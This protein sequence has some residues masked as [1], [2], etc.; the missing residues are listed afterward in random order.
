MTSLT[1]ALER[2]SSGYFKEGDLVIDHVIS[3]EIL[4]Q[5]ITWATGKDANSVFI[6]GTIEEEDA[7]V[8]TSADQLQVALNAWWVWACADGRSRNSANMADSLSNG[9]ATLDTLKTYMS[10]STNLRK[11]NN[12]VTAIHSLDQAQEEFDKKSMSH[13]KIGGSDA[14][15]DDNSFI[16]LVAKGIIPLYADNE[17]QVSGA[18]VSL[19][20]PNASR[21]FLCA[22]CVYMAYLFNKYQGEIKKTVKKIEKERQSLNSERQ[23][24]REANL[25]VSLDASPLLKGLITKQAMLQRVINEINEVYRNLVSGGELKTPY[26]LW[27]FLGRAPGL[28][29]D[30]SK[31]T[32]GTKVDGKYEIHEGSTPSISLRNMSQNYTWLVTSKNSTDKFRY[33]QFSSQSVN[34]GVY[35]ICQGAKAMMDAG[36][37]PEIRYKFYRMATSFALAPFTMFKTMTMNI[38]LMGPPGTG[39][40]TLADKLGKFAAAVGWLTSSEMIEPK[41]SEIISNVRGETA[42]N[43][44]SYLN[45][46]LGRMCFID[47]AYSLTPP[48]DAAGKE[49]A[50]ELTEFTTNHKGM[51]MIVV[52]GYVEEMTNDFFTSNIGLPRRFPTKIILGVKTPR[53]CLDA[54]IWQLMNKMGVSGSNVGGINIKQLTKQQRPFFI[55]QCCIWFPVFNILLGKRFKQQENGLQKQLG[56]DPVNLLKYYYADVDLL[57]EIYMRYLMSEGLFYKSRNWAGGHKFK[58]GG[59]SSGISASEPFDYSDIVTRVVNDWLSTR[60]GENTRVEAIN[61]SKGG[62]LDLPL[63]DDIPLFR[64]MKEYIQDPKENGDQLLHLAKDMIAKNICLWPIHY[65]EP[66]GTRGQDFA[67]CP[68]SSVGISFKA[69]DINAPGKVPFSGSYSWITKLGA[70]KA[71]LG[72]A[73]GAASLADHKKILEKKKRA[74]ARIEKKYKKKHQGR[75]DRINRMK[76]QHPVVLADIDTS[77]I[78]N[79]EDF[80]KTLNDIE[81]K[82]NAMDQQQQLIQSLTDTAL[83]TEDEKSNLELLLREKQL[84]LESKLIQSQ[85]DITQVQQQYSQELDDKSQEIA[86]LSQKLNEKL[87]SDDEARI[88]AE[89]QERINNY[90]QV[91]QNQDVK[92]KRMQENHLEKISGL[93]EQIEALS[94][95]DIA[96]MKKKLQDIENKYEEKI[97]KIDIEEQK[98]EDDDVD[99]EDMRAELEDRKTKAMVNIQNQIDALEKEQAQNAQRKKEAVRAAA[100]AAVAIQ[101]KIQEAERRR[102]SKLNK[103]IKKFKTAARAIGKLSKGASDKVRDNKK[104][105]LAGAVEVAKVK[106][107]KQ[108]IKKLKTAARAIGKLSKGASDK[109]RDNKKVALAGAV[110]VA[111]VKRAKQRIKKLKDN[112]KQF[113]RNKPKNLRQGTLE[114]LLGGGAK[115]HPKNNTLKF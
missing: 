42:I 53:Q 90:E 61:I 102:A 14:I 106:R 11:V 4:E 58:F 24:Y 82:L 25:E 27:E 46:S 37:N 8:Q 31:I 1:N 86:E 98:N 41:A 85:G 60:T 54:F 96:N 38:A 16:Q 109:V 44:R 73:V 18:A 94:G 88:R 22:K 105:A 19:E 65:P 43:T 62:Y 64:K 35:E 91:Q 30:I 78:A 29:D 59:S 111:K 2:Q 84:E 108:R 100:A 48:G 99:F 112:Y 33:L 72:G 28:P 47:E 20:N 97:Q 7:T 10:S 23:S 50:D 71:K 103:R 45:A 6:M 49:F 3:K 87:D 51:L 5:F 12:T 40:S 17:Q 55:S 81:G 15:V 69:K 63:T 113:V 21:A 107:A 52:A 9:S 36:V 13:N 93:Y 95:L 68:V 104:V 89:L 57:A 77:S 39:K 34:N 76:I 115:L 70:I 26:L 114:V 67:Y 75:I 83:K 66:Q 32:F 110:E 74:L 80:E 79:D 92:L 56:D 101:N